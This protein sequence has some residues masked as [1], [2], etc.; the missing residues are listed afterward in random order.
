MSHVHVG[1]VHMACSNCFREAREIAKIT[2]RHDAREDLR[3]R[4]FWAWA[5]VA[6]SLAL[7]VVAAVILWS[8]GRIEG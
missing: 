2:G 1:P 6:F 3:T 4:R 7:A 8:L 5:L